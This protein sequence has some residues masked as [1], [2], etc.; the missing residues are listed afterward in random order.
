[1]RLTL[2]DV[3]LEVR[4]TVGLVRLHAV[5]PFCES[6]TVP[7][8]PLMAVTRIVEVPDDPTLTIIPDGPATIV[9]S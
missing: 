9:K 2:A 5:P 6:P 3:A 7:E 1:V 8:N 4:V